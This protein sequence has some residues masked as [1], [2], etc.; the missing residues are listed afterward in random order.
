M[1]TTRRGLFASARQLL[2]TSLQLVQVRLALIGNDV[3]VGVQRLFDSIVLALLSVVAFG[4]GV[5]M[6]CALIL[7]V[8]QE[9]HRPY[10]AGAL[11]LVFMAFGYG[12]IRMARSKQRASVGAFAATRAE[13]ARDLAALNLRNSENS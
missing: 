8:V 10:A 6:L 1:T 3:E 7:M 5:L 13:L 4:I 2:A 12:L 9:S 11:A